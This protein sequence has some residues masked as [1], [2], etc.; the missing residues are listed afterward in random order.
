MA[1][2]RAGGVLESVNYEWIAHGF[3]TNKPGRRNGPGGAAA[4]RA[5]F[6]STGWPLER[7]VGPSLQHLWH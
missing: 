5:L 7:C 1:S 6:A 4:A 2:P 3:S